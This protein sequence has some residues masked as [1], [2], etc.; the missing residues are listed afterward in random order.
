MTHETYE[1]PVP[2]RH[3]QE[4]TQVEFIELSRVPGPAADRGLALREILHHVSHRT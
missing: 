3:T 1:R 4:N 2:G